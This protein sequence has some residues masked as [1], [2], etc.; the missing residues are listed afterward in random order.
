MAPQHIAVV[1]LAIAVYGSFAW[2]FFGHFRRP[3]G[4]PLLLQ[5][6]AAAATALT[7]A[8]VV[9]LW[10]DDP[11]W[12]AAAAI[13]GYAAAAALYGWAVA[14]TRSQRPSLAFSGDA[15]TLLVAAGPYRYVRHPF[16]AAY[17]IYWLAGAAALRE[18]WLVPAIAAVAA[19][20][21][22]AALQEERWFARSAMTRAYG[23]YRRSTGMFLPRLKAFR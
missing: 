2:G 17:L 8:Q 1:A 13:L 4:V 10:R 22:L 3:Q 16:Y 12:W 6:T 20:Y 18:L 9:R 21:V 14:T 5:A 11:G 23:E 19:L 15:P 7:V